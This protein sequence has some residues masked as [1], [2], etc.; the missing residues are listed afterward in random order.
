M[1]G[2]VY[3]LI[4]SNAKSLFWALIVGLMVSSML[5][6]EMKLELDI[7]TDRFSLKI[8]TKH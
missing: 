6:S 7:A 8:E 3:T 5:V 1:L 4:S 2:Q